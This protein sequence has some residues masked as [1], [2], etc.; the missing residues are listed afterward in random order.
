VVSI[1]R[2]SGDEDSSS[3]W[4]FPSVSFRDRAGRTVVVE[5]SDAFV[6]GK[7]RIGN[8]LEI[9]YEPDHP[10]RAR[11]VK[12]IHRDGIGRVCLGLIAATVG[13]VILWAALRSP[14]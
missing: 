9:L 7:L 10:E 5:L 11:L 13:G 3:V 8:Q 6:E 1:R 2:D 14:P 12:R 4:H